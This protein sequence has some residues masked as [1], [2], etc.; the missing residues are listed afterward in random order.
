MAKLSDLGKYVG[1][2]LPCLILTLLVTWFAAQARQIGYDPPVLFA[3]VVGGIL[4]F[5]LVAC[6]RI[7]RMIDLWIG[8]LTTCAMV[9]ICCAGQAYVIYF[10]DYVAADT[11]DHESAPVVPSATA[12][13]KDPPPFSDFIFGKLPTHLM[14]WTIDSM[15]IMA[16]TVLIV[17]PTLR[18]PSCKHCS[19][20]YRTQ[21]SGVVDGETAEDIVKICGIV[22]PGEPVSA[23][24]RLLGCKQDCGPPGLEL[25][26]ETESESGTHTGRYRVWIDQSKRRRILELIDTV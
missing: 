24:Y 13:K 23:Q 14:R 6:L 20:W 26:W 10:Q 7:S 12:T 11:V 8:I 5:G 2:L 17:V 25:V 19:S 16:T 21:T 4:G 15:L 3:L 9:A 18:Q 22:L 1:W